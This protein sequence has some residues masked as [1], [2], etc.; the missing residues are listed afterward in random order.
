VLAHL[1]GDR[2]LSA[3]PNWLGWVA[4]VSGIAMATPIFW[5]SSLGVLVWVLIVAALIHVRSGV[6][7]PAA[8]PAAIEPPRSPG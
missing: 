8:A 1:K 5:I 4:V 7:R 3:L 2:R 6:A